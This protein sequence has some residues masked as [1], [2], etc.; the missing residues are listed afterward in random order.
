[1]FCET[2][3]S[4]SKIL[5]KILKE[6][7]FVSDGKNIDFTI[8]EIHDDNEGFLIKTKGIIL[9]YNEKL[10]AKTAI[11]STQHRHERTFVYEL[12]CVTCVSPDCLVKF[13]IKELNNEYFDFVYDIPEIDDIEED[14]KKYGFA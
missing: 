4:V 13:K 14:M 1:M 5:S 11:Y 10:N 8:D 2:S 7:Y 9:V 3:F 12:F 6:Q